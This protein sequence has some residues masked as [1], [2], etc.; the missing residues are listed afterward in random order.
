LGEHAS[1]E[2]IMN[3][4]RPVED[5]EMGISIVDLGLIYRAEEL[6]DAIEVEYTLTYPGCPV[7][8]QLREEI[9]DRLF[10]SFPARKVRIALVWEPMW[11][12]ERMTEALR[13]EM[14]YPI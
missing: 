1:S 2:D 8:E 11:G 9:V 13:L 12:P 4:L 7:G 10:R 3:A 5:P 6:P 14:G